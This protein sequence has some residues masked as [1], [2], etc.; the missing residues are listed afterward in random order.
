M[1]N[2]RTL[3]LIL[4][5][6]TIALVITLFEVIPMKNMMSI[7]TKP[8][9]EH[10][11]AVLDPGPSPMLMEEVRKQKAPTTSISNSNSK[12]KL[13]HQGFR[14]EEEV[15]R[16]LAEEA[17]VGHIS[18]GGLVN[19]I[20]KA[21]FKHRKYF[22]ELGFIPVS[23]DF[24]RKVFNAI[25]QKEAEEVSKSLGLSLAN[26][27]VANFFPRLDGFTLVQ[28]LETW[29]GKFQS[30]RH[31]VE[32]TASYNIKRHTFSVDHDINLNFSI[33]LKIMLIGLIEPIIKAIVVFGDPTSS[34][35]VFSFDT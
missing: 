28:F 19:T 10:I 33:A 29:L 11:A 13:V 5:A 24:L 15:V 14:I 2:S 20:L 22:E 26:E 18:V 23:K 6:I 17:N 34:T 35:L 4:P 8:E 1:R 21:H 3:D 30:C 7:S 32:D 9:E 27:Y 25:P 12:I 16:L 31:R